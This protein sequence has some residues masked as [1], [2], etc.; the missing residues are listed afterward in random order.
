MEERGFKEVD[1]LEGDCPTETMEREEGVAAG[2]PAT[3][4]VGI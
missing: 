2:E 4:S 3:M 1:Q